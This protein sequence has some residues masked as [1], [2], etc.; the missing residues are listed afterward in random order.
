MQWTSLQKLEN[1]E[2]MTCREIFMSRGN[3]E[4]EKL[5]TKYGCETNV[6]IERYRTVI[7]KQ[8]HAEVDT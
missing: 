7:Y 6:F 5:A 2:N 8:F 4:I 1:T 3:A